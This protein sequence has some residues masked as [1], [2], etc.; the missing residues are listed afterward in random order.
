MREKGTAGNRKH[1]TLI[2][3]HKLK[4]IRRLGSGQSCVIMAT[5]NTRSSTIHD[6]KKQKGQLQSF[7]APCGII[8]KNLHQDS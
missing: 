6:I 8:C 1:G 4:T 2:I 5:Y 7:M 3:S